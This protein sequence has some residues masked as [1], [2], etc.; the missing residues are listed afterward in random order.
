[1]GK[2]GMHFIYSTLRKGHQKALEWFS[3]QPYISCYCK[4]KLRSKV[5]SLSTCLLLL[6]Q[7]SWNTS[8]SLLTVFGFRGNRSYRRFDEKWTKILSLG[9]ILRGGW[10]WSWPESTLLVPPRTAVLC[11]TTFEVTIKGLS[12]SSLSLTYMLS[13]R[14]L[15]CSCTVRTISLSVR[16]SASRLEM[17]GELLKMC[18]V[19]WS[20]SCEFSNRFFFP[21]QRLS[22]PK[23]YNLDI[24]PR[25]S[26]RVRIKARTPLRLDPLGA[27]ASAGRL[28]FGTRWSHHE[29]AVH[30]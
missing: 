6:W 7:Q 13:T 24:Q 11:V 27:Q 15:K 10:Q 17:R 20:H 1:M 29:I 26:W 23:R 25:H 4:V 22:L 5:S 28:R 16:K 14:V 8:L 30:L 2:S 18:K 19:I 3:T 9:L 12:L 21:L